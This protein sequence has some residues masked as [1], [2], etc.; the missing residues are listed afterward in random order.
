MSPFWTKEHDLRGPFW[1]RFFI[2]CVNDLKSR[3][4]FV[5]Q[6]DS[7]ISGNKKLSFCD[8]FFI[9]F[10][11]FSKRLPGSVFRGSQCRTFTNIYFSGV[12]FDF[13][14]FP[15]PPKIYNCHRTKGPKVVA[16]NGQGNPGIDAA[17]HET[18]IITVPFGPTGF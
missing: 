14:D 17:F 1:H 18:I 11:V 7:I 13:L 4:M 8:Q 6:H 16:P 3:K 12:I 15:N 2:I 5:F 9:A 10:Q